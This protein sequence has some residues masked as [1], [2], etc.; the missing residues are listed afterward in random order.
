[1]LT[2]FYAGLAIVYVGLGYLFFAE[3]FPV[4]KEKCAWRQLLF[5][6][7]LSGSAFLQC[8]ALENWYVL[9]ISLLLFA[10]LDAAIA[11][12]F[13][14]TSYSGAFVWMW[15]YQ[16]M[17]GVLKY[18]EMLSERV[19]KISEKPRI[20]AAVQI[21]ILW[22]LAILL[23]LFYIQKQWK[24][25]GFAKMGRML[26]EE[27]HILFTFAAATW[28]ALTVV[29]YAEQRYVT[30]GNLVLDIV[31]FGGIGAALKIVYRYRERA[32]RMQKDFLMQQAS[33][34]REQQT[35]KEWHAKDAKK[36]HDI[37]HIFLFLQ[38]CI[39][40]EDTKKAEEY[41]SNYLKEME[42]NPWKIWTGCSEVDFSINYY[43]QLMEE[44]GIAFRMETDIHE[45]PV[46]EVDMM[47]LLG[48]LL[49]NAMNAAK[50]CEKGKQNVFLKMQTVNEMF[51]LTVENT[52]NQIP[53][54]RD[55]KFLTSKE[56]N[57][58][59]GWGIENVKALVEKYHGEIWFSYTA[60]RFRVELSIWGNERE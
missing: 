58:Y 32:C 50:A 28:S 15:S 14:R 44:Q 34:L 36:M 2:V 4:K 24:R 55:G 51:F 6:A 10:I 1:M 12:M 17:I 25:G 5:I 19:F 9:P 33:W 46:E 30:L 35:M 52:S 53:E 26:K 60:E 56:E 21:R 48:N 42:N 37:K 8:Y 54:Q 39:R 27:P 57:G 31:T 22:M 40:E 13:F 45:I 7:A 3:M 16:I 23:F 20:G 38:K 29:S 47:I 11:T 49:D 59:H 18:W 41:L 43:R